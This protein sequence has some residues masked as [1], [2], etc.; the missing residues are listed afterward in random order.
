MGSTGIGDGDMLFRIDPVTGDGTPVDFL[1][2]FGAYGMAVEYV[3]EP[4]TLVLLAVGTLG[5]LTCGW[6]RRKG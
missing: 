4:S 3:P 5:L 2:G 6:R 1:R